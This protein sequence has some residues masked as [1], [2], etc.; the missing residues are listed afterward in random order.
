[1]RKKVVILGSTG[2][3]GLSALK[4][5]RDLPDRME[6]VGLAA[7][8]QGKLLPGTHIPVVSPERLLEARPDYVLILPWNLEQE[9]RRQLDGVRAWGGRFVTAVPQIA[10]DP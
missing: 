3:I 6:V 8:K 4:V 5:A 9:I 1:M 2:S 10:V 7:H